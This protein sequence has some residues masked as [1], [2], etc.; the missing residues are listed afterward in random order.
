MKMIVDKNLV[1]ALVGLLSFQLRLGAPHTQGSNPPAAGNPAYHQSL[2]A[3]NEAVSPRRLAC[4]GIQAGSLRPQNSK[5]AANRA[6]R[7]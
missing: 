1:V 5:G 4:P 3:S 6:H 7:P 2:S